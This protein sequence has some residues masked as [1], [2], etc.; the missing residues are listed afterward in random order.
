[1]LYDLL[2]IEED[3]SGLV[4]IDSVIHSIFH[5]PAQFAKRL[6]RLCNQE[7]HEIPLVAAYLSGFV[8]L[9]KLLKCRLAALLKREVELT[10][11][12][13]VCHPASVGKELEL[14]LAEGDGE[15]LVATHFLISIV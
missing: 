9:M 4:V 11:Y 3:V 7:P 15:L 13:A 6:Y 10:N 14:T 8:V 1:M 5:A 2:H 12:Q